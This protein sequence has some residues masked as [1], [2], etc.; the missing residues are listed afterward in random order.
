MN[1]A[2][3]QL[4]RYGSLAGLIALTLMVGALGSLVTTP[5][6]PTW[7]AGLARPSFAPPN[8]VFAPVWTTLYVMMAVAAWLIWRQ[9]PSPARRAALRLFA[10]QLALNTIWSFLFFGFGRID[11]A[12]LEIAVLWAAIVATTFAYAGLSRAAAWLM[13]PYLAWVS[14]AAVLNFAFWR[15][16]G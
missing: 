7:Y 2:T 1:G 8:W 16:N 13:V 10:V 12:L 4:S 5:A 15:L 14:F 9:P 11:L 6:I 3:T